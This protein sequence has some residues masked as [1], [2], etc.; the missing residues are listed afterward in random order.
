ME[1][2]QAIWNKCHNILFSDKKWNLELIKVLSCHHSNYMNDVWS[3]SVTKMFNVLPAVFE[4]YPKILLLYTCATIHI[5]TDLNHVTW[6]LLITCY[7]MWSL[8]TRKRNVYQP[9]VTN[10]AKSCFLAKSEIYSWPKPYHVTTL[11]TFHDVWSVFVIKKLNYLPAIFEKY[12]KMLLFHINVNTCPQWCWW[13][14]QCQRLQ[15]G[16]W[17]STTG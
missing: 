14:Q 17:D 15:Q 6:L 10:A 11:I 5:W 2:L 8:C 3:V 9:F 16:N 12:H 1:C 13:C 4:T 7:D